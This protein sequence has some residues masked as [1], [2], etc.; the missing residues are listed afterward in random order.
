LRNGQLFGL[1]GDGRELKCEAF[2][3]RMELDLNP[4]KIVD[5]VVGGVKLFCGMRERGGDDDAACLTTG[6][7]S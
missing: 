3:P 6:P 2:V 7:G 5:E 1:P 4:N